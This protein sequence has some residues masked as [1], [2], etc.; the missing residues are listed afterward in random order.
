MNPTTNHVVWFSDP[1]IKAKFMPIVKKFMRENSVAVASSKYTNYCQEPVRCFYDYMKENHKDRFSDISKIYGAFRLDTSLNAIS[2]FSS[3][4]I[5][6]MRKMGIDPTNPTSRRRYAEEANILDELKHVPHFWIELD[7]TII[8]FSGW[9][10]FVQ[11]K[12]ASEIDA[13]RFIKNYRWA[14]VEKLRGKK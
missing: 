14:H 8:D 12:L 11:S 10:Q 2:D 13:S 1:V 6:E 3:E 7:G 9:Y 5:T 4:E